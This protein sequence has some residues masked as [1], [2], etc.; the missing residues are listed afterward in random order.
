MGRGRND[1]ADFR[2]KP[3]ATNALASITQ[4]DALPQR[5]PDNTPAML[6]HRHHVSMENH[7]GLMAEVETTQAT[8]TAE[9]EDARA[10]CSPGQGL[11]IGW[12]HAP[13]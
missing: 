12:T 2:G 13:S 7:N 4:P 5:K 10:Q 9:P 11:G 6:C 8:G 1:A 3:R